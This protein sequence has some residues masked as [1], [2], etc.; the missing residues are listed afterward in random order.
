MVDSKKYLAFLKQKKEMFLVLF[1]KVLEKLLPFY[2]QNFEN[3]KNKLDSNKELKKRDFWFDICF[4]FV[5]CLIMWWNC[6]YSYNNC[7]MLYYDI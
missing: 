1:Q 4:C 2:K 5:I 6:L 3:I 7:S